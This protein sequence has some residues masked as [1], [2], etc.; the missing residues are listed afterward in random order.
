MATTG[1]RRSELCG[2]QI[3][4]IDIDLDLDLVHVVFNYV[5]RGGQRVRKDTKTH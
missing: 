4:D 2:P 3:C 1:V 5:V